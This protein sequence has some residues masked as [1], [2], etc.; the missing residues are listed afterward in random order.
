MDLND[1]EEN[2]AEA[3]VQE[4]ANCRLNTEAKGR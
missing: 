4:K 1:K 2:G 3:E